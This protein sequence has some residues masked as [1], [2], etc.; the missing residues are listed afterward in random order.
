MP[1]MRPVLEEEAPVVLLVDP[2]A[3]FDPALELDELAVDEDEGVVRAAGVV[4]GATLRVVRPEVVVSSSRSVVG[5]ERLVELA[6]ARV[7]AVLL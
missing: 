5:T 2:S 3:A 6:L 4:V 7:E 1:T